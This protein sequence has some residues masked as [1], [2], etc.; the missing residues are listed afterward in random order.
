MS[1]QHNT[2]SVTVLP[3]KEDEIF[4]GFAGFVEIWAGDG[5]EIGDG[6]RVTEVH[7]D[8]IDA[9]NEASW[10]GYRD[11]GIHVSCEEYE[12]RGERVD[13]LAQLFGELAAWGMRNPRR[14]FRG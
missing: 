12:S 9:C 13:P 11:I 5:D 2:L 1:E 8:A 14:A 6:Q 7:D 4:A 10:K 3:V